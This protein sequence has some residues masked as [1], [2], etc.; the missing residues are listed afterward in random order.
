MFIE[1][2]FR[3]EKYV[4]YKKIHIFQNLIGIQDPRKVKKHCYRRNQINYTKSLKV[5]ALIYMFAKVLQKIVKT[6][7]LFDRVDHCLQA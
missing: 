5:C 3:L 2:H 1:T 6:L 7:K 4:S